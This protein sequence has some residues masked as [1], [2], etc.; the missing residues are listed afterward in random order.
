[1]S[2]FEEIVFKPIGVL[3]SPFKNPEETPRWY[4]ISDEEGIIEVFEEYEAGLEGIEDYEYLDVLYYFHLARKDLL[5]VKPPHRDGLRG[6]F[7]TRSPHRPN[8][9]A[10]STVKLIKRDGR[11]LKVKGLD[12]VDG[13]PV[14]DIKPHKE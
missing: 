11:F 14:L 10:L 12:A 5:K 9:I 6:V 1:M 8:P 2:G 3:K 4:T 13:T 7:A